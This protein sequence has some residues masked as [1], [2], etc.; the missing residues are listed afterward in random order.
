MIEIDE[1][2]IFDEI[3]TNKP[4]SVCISAPDGLMIYL[5]DISTRIKKEFDVDVFIMGDSCYGSCDSTNFE[6]K[7][8][9]AELAFNIG[10][11]ISFEKLGDRTVMID[12]FDN[13]DFE[14]AIK[15]SVDV[16]K[17]FK[18]IGMVTFTL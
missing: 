14:A 13:I 15:K 10:H 7:R 5:E 1:T 8:I 18:V 16:L 4:K 6:A 17:Q 9:G 12:A 11:T 3:R 2:K